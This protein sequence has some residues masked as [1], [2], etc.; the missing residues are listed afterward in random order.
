M[1]KILS[2][3]LTIALALSLSI[4]A[5]AAKEP[6]ARP[7][8][9]RFQDFAPPQAST[10][11]L[12][13][14]LPTVTGITAVW[15]GDTEGLF[16]RLYGPFFHP[17]NVAITVSF[18][19]GGPETL[20]HWY[21]NGYGWF[22]EIFY[23]YDNATG[24]VTFFYSD[25]NLRAA[26]DDT[27]RRGDDWSWEDYQ[28][29]LPRA[30][31]SIPVNLRL[32]HLNG[33][34]KTALKLGEG[35]RIPAG[36]CVIFSFTPAKSGQYYFYSENH[37]SAE[38]YGEL[39]D[40]GFNFLTCHYNYERHDFGIVWELQAGKAYYMLVSDLD[41]S[42]GEFNVTLRSDIR[43]LDLW[44]MIWDTLTG[45]MLLRRWALYESDLYSFPGTSDWLDNLDH[46]SVIMGNGLGTWL[47]LRILALFGL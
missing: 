29:T 45:G 41:G 40:A 9:P 33:L 38:P 5:F 25:S 34:P 27:L 6:P 23:D 26:Y 28:A 17:E 36:E 43:K 32:E 4:C 16:D 18:A 35:Q 14:E 44:G 31:F 8:A 2:V 7:G 3:L 47:G 30:S 37:G 13:F 19:E 20:D 11:S 15:N 24:K 46:N 10:Q 22:W 12:I 39:Y 42:A 1:K 21:D